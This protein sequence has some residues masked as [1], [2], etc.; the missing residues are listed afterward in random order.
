MTEPIGFLVWCPERG[1]PTYTHPNFLGA[2]AEA[3]RLKR[4]NPGCRFVVMAPCE[5]MSMIGYSLGWSRGREEGL[6]QSHREIMKAE[7]VE[8][9]NMD[10][11]HDLRA[12]L[13]RTAKIEDNA[14]AFQSIVADALLWFDGFAA[15][16]AHRESYD[17]PRIP[18]RDQLRTLNGALQDL[19]EPDASLGEIPF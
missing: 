7:A 15:A 10:A 19:A 12:R 2:I 4:A 17:Q 13:R 8:D 16:H 9:R 18:D 1:F 14:K 11:A 3:D 5:D 6:A